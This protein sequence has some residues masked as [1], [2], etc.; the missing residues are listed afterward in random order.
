MNKFR[1]VDR[2]ILCQYDLNEEFFEKLNLEIEDIIPLRKVFVLLT[3]EGKKILKLTD[4]S[5]ERIR[6]ISE[7]LNYIS[8]E[9]D[10]VLS[11]Y[12]SKEGEITYKFASNNYVLLNMIEGREATFT[13]PVEVEM[14]AKSIANMHNA[15]KGIFNKLST[16]IVKGNLGEYLPYQ[17]SKAK[18]DL[19]NIKEY[20]LR[21][22]YKNEFDKVFLEHVDSNINQIQ[23]SIELLAMCEYNSMLEDFNKRV[24]CHNDLAHHNFIIDGD[25]VKIIDFDYCKIDTRAVDIANYSIKVIKN[26]CYDLNKFKLILDSYNSIE[27]LSKQEIKLI[28][29]IISFPKDFITI[30]RDYYYKQKKWDYEVFFNRLK[31]KIGNENHRQDFIENFIT[32]MSEYFY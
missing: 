6:F 12:E 10:S 7:A 2:D 19:I 13:N 11:Y 8:K 28:Y 26:S 21:F 23:K 1:Y 24:L 5:E 27:K 29:A 3:N 17:F 15:S 18:E 16:E 14:C 32:E 20:V 22:R 31:D 9:Y 30:S 25:N 4:S